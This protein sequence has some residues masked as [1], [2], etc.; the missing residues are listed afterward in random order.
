MQ[1]PQTNAAAAGSRLGVRF[2]ATGRLAG[3]YPLRL[4]MPAEPR[5]L[6]PGK[7]LVVGGYRARWKASFRLSGDRIDPDAISRATGLTPTRSH[8]QGE[9]MPS[10]DRVWRQGLWSLN[11]E[12]AVFDSETELEDHLI[13]LLERLE[14]QADHLHQLMAE[15][16]LK[17][18]LLR[19]LMR[20]SKLASS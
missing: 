1:Q 7:Y 4:S 9:V 6:P 10:R 3:T 15:H 13:W 19:L 14:P 5:N 2:A 8:E 20:A 16:G 17:G 12:D 11:T 18:L